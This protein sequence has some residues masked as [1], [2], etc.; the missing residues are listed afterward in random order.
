MRVSV[1][2][3]SFEH[4]R[5]VAR[6]LDG[7]LEQRGVELELL[8]GDD[9]STD[10]T[11]AVIAEYAR[12]RPD[13]IR[14]FFPDRNLGQGG[15][16]IF[17]HLIERARGDYLAMLDADDY[18]TAPDKL[19][20]QVAYL[21]EHPECSMC[22]HDVMCVFEDG[23]RADG[24]YN[25]PKQPPEVDLGALLDRC[26]VASCS[27]L[28]RRATIAPLP[29]W[30]FDVPWGDWPLYFMAAEHGALHYLPEVMGVYRIHGGG[31]Y[32]RL[33]RL[34]ALEARTDFYRGLRVPREYEGARRRKLAQTWVKRALE[35]NRLVQRPAAVRA[36]GTAVRVS[37]RLLLD[38]PGALLSRRRGT[39]ETTPSGPR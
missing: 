17:S 27:P 36:L 2:M 38:A 30:Y 11:R 14:T 6:A 20:R 18:W 29:S 3:T 23:A 26:V 21:D 28:F 10:G 34:E 5:F 25:G 39:A 9:A 19:V 1:L 24:R 22:F 33:S 15:K 35:H 31:M 8:V 16:A 32:S 7:V 12:A 13:V 4:E 37:P